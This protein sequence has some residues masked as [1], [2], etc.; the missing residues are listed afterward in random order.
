LKCKGK[1]KERRREKER[2]PPGGHSFKEKA[3]RKM[4]LSGSKGTILYSCRLQPNI[5]VIKIKVDLL[6]GIVSRKKGKVGAE[7]IP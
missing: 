3:G 7:Q 1:G 4:N 5:M 6:E 2:R